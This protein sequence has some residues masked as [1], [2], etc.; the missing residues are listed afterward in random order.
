MPTLPGVASSFAQE[1]T[2]IATFSTNTNL[3]IIDV[4][5]HDKSGKPVTN[6]NKETFTILENGKRQ[7]ISVFELQ[8]LDSEVLPEIV[9]NPKTL[10]DGS[11]IAKAPATP[12]Q[13]T[14]RLF[15]SKSPKKGPLLI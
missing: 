12:V 7:V 11:N 13:G 2:R 8:K 15:A 4:Y 6:L 9:E 3:V 10:I 14:R 1:D 5:A